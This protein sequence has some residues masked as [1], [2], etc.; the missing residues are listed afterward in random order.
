MSDRRPQDFQAPP[1]IDNLQR[2]AAII[3][4]IGIIASVVGAMTNAEQ[5]YRSY[6]VAYLWV[7]GPTT[8]CLALLMI[9][10]LSGGAWGL[11]VRR[12]LEAAA[13]TL[14]LTAVLFVPVILGMPHLFEW[15]HADVVSR[16]P[17][18]QAKAPYLNTTFFLIRAGIYFAVWG[19]LTFI[20]T[21]WSRAQDT[22]P[23]PPPADR[24]FRTLS[25]PGVLLYG[26]TI[27]F[28]SFDWVMSLDPHWYSTLYGLLFMVGQGLTACAF[29]AVI[30]FIISRRP[31]MD[32]VL[33]AEKFHDYGKL[34][35]AFTMLWAY[36]A[37]SQFL[38]I[39]SGNLPE[40][41]TYYVRRLNTGWVTLSWIILFGVFVIPY[42]MLLSRDLKRSAS[43]LAYLGVFI[44]IMRYVDLYWM[45]QPTLHPEPALHW[46]DLATAVG[47]MGLWLAAF[48]WNLKG[49]SLVPVNDPYLEEALS[50]GH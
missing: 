13:R 6:L 47:L 24:K 37:F 10:H 12:V 41:V 4:A 39:W 21:G 9:H 11:G 44:L 28:A 18:L 19:A 38:I 49:Q 43:R 35:L 15:T 5:F 46:L 50:D 23:T 2:T 20:L 40:E 34:T 31:P 29:T 45:I 48:C 8:G 25:G 36:L 14:P 17:I 32:H 3:G 30:A 27:S 16:D 33:S 7:L 26:I 42:C 1:E 22:T